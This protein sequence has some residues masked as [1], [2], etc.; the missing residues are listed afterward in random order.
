MGSRRPVLHFESIWVHGYLVFCILKTQLE[1]QINVIRPAFLPFY[2]DINNVYNSNSKLWLSESAAI[3]P[4]L[5]SSDRGGYDGE[6]VTVVI[7]CSDSYTPGLLL[8]WWKIRQPVTFY[9]ALWPTTF[10]CSTFYDVLILPKI[11]QIKCVWQLWIPQLWN[12]G[13]NY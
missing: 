8:M 12:G 11:K 13:K 9:N 7:T 2:A 3:I 1:R 10:I 6:L 5:A 4:I